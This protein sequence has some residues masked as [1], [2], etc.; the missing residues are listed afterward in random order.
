[1]QHA[2]N[3]PPKKKQWTKKISS[4]SKAN[5]AEHEKHCQHK[6][7]P[8]YQC[9]VSFTPLVIKAYYK[10]CKKLNKDIEPVGGDSNITVRCS[11]GKPY[12]NP[13]P[14][15]AK[16]LS[17]PLLPASDLIY[18]GVVTQQTENLLRF[19]RVKVTK[20]Q[21][22]PIFK[23]EMK[24]GAGLAT[25]PIKSLA[26]ITQEAWASKTIFQVW[27]QNMCRSFFY[28]FYCLF[29]R[30][31]KHRKVECDICKKEFRADNLKKNTGRPA[32]KG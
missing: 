19:I 12:M 15:V 10:L 30:P 16:E 22:H 26:S 17:H 7:F 32:K 25:Y 1:M 6:K 21:M 3:P 23:R 14:S 20:A 28:F 13:T 2:N 4:K 9:G 8:C 18:F 29:F 31:N 5:L 27:S 24:T 11:A